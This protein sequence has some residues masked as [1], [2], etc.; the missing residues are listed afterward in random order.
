MDQ[1][2]APK[3]P[4]RRF[5]PLA[6]AP[7]L[8]AGAWAIT[9]QDGGQS[10]TLDRTAVRLA[11]VES[12]V[13]NE[14][15]QLRGRVQPRRTIYLDA[16]E[17][18]RVERRLVEPGTFVKQ[19]QPLVELSNSGLLLSV[20]SREAD[21]AEQLNNLRNTRLNM[22]TERLSLQSQLL[23][24]DHQVATLERQLRQQLRLKD[25]DFVSDELLAQ[26]RETLAY[27]QRKR[28]L[29]LAKQQQDEALRQI[30][31]AQLEDSSRQLS[32]NLEVARQNLENLTIKAPADGFLSMLE[33]EQG[34]SKAPGAR[35]GQLD[36]TDDF[37]VT[38]MIDEYYLSQVQ[39]GMS[40]RVEVDGQPHRLTLT[41][42][43]GRVVNSQFEIELAFEGQTPALRRGQ[44]LNLT[45]NL[46]EEARQAL[47]IP[48]GAFFHHTGGNWIFVLDASGKQAEKRAIALGKRSGDHLE[49]RAG[50]SQGEQV[51]ISSYQSFQDKERLNFND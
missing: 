41:K 46:D 22:E 45:L 26:T 12:Q 4:L 43:S 20:I 21:V 34:E 42:V 50:L 6:L 38:A 18:G 16:I 10:L 17:G 29:T 39:P 1:Q 48:K 35:L 27:Y 51:V 32:R 23:E 24:I 15:V 47:V 33:A 44:S 36:L 8:L 14:A 37:K 11:R 19:G 13:I 5:W 3:K 7:L 30:Q 31:L 25:R 49:V 28:E 40:A 9:A 2:I